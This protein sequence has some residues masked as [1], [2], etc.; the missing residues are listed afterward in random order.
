MAR[1]LTMMVTLMHYSQGVHDMHKPCASFGL[2]PRPPCTPEVAL[3]CEGITLI[4]QEGWL[5]VS[6]IHAV[7]LCSTHHCCEPRVS[8][9]LC[10]QTLCRNT[11]PGAPAADATGLFSPKGLDSAGHLWQNSKA[12]TK[13]RGFCSQ[14]GECGGKCMLS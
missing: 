11:R 13:N 4:L 14:A 10:T 3:C 8:S 7:S 12:L 5:P 2:D 9:G 1:Q 6:N